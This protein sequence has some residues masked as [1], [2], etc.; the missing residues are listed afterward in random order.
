M[1]PLKKYRQWLWICVVWLMI[2]GCSSSGSDEQADSGGIGG[3]GVN[4][5]EVTAY[6]SIFVNGIEMHTGQAEIYVEGEYM[7]TGDST[8][9]AYLPIGQRV[10]IQG[11]ISDPG[12]ATARRVDA[13][14]RVRGPVWEIEWVGD[15]SLR[16]D[17][18]GQT[19][20]VT[21]KTTTYGISTEDLEL[22]MVIEVSGPVDGDGAVHAGM[23]SLVEDQ[24]TSV[25]LKGQAAEVD[26]GQSVF[27]INEL[28][29]DFS[30]VQIG[31]DTPSAGETVAVQG[32]LSGNTLMASS[33]E[34]FDD[35]RFDSAGQIIT[36]GFITAALA[37]RQWRMG[38]YD[39]QLDDDTHFETL[40]P[41]DLEAGIRVQVRGRL[42]NR[43]ILATRIEPAF[44][45]R[46]ESNVADV[47][48]SSG[49]L[50]LEG[51]PTL[52][53][54]TDQLTRVRGNASELVDIFTGDHVRIFGLASGD[55]AV[56]AVEIFASP[57]QA[58]AERWVLQGPVTAVSN[59]MFAILS[60]ELDTSSSDAIEFTGPDEE[61]LSAEEFLSAM[62][63]GTVVRVYGQWEADQLIYQSMT[64]IR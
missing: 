35:D 21:S 59:P 3:S 48:Y 17:V 55:A 5:G 42:Q 58:Q 57:S 8:A 62:D 10:V 11:D 14:Y 32:N 26:H 38:V 39:I 64:I 23:I 44:R 40:S 56:T 19:V 1:N 46:L 49:Q 6:G 30:Q 15:D 41:E 60:T 43:I 28:R 18:M 51:A 53:I 36:D 45:V 50:T 22:Y 27:R 29:I 13:Y 33:V 24:N 31:A 63:I 9:Q 47:D 34:S 16:L 20:L 25:G 2:F 4:D 37:A 54:S 7:G 61:P 52:V 12:N